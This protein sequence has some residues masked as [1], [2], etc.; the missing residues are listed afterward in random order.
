MMPTLSPNT[1]AI[2]LLTAP[3]I[4]GRGTSSSELLTPGE[5]KRLARHLREI[6]RQPADLVSPEAA[7][8]LRACHPVIDESRLQ[9]LLGRGF[10]LS[11]VIERWQTRALWVVSRADTQ[12]P[13]RLKARLRED[14]PAVIYGCGDMVLLETGGLAVV[15][16]RHVAD[17]LIDYTMAV[18]R[19]AA[20]AGRTLVS[21][22]AKG[23]DQAA[24]RGALEAGG[25]VCG[26]LADSLEKTT[27]N[28]EHRNLLLDG[29]LVLMSPYDPSAGFNVG[30]AMQRNKLIY[31]MADSSLVVGSDL[32]KGGTWAGATEQLDKLKFVPVYVRSTGEPSIGLDALREK[33][34]LPWPNPQDVDALRA[35][36]DTV[37]PASVQPPQSAFALFSTDETTEVPLSMP[38]VAEPPP[39]IETPSES[40]PP[41]A[42]PPGNKALE[43]TPEPAAPADRLFA[44]VR[45]AITSLLKTTMKD[46][47]VAATLD[48][49]SAQAKAWLQRL[50]NEGVIEKQKKP[51]G[52]I[53]KQSRLFE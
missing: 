25:K 9:R 23:I 33:G 16:S 5:Y 46:S 11:Q 8:L 53:V 49:S 6:Q 42:E 31:A 38:W 30:N 7:D 14:A 36:F 18:G 37:T 34:A 29:Q 44:V 17:A 45:E 51:A 28:R 26:V 41:P 12:Y 10:L 4:A 52:Y 2:L 15:G 24:M 13:R 39:A 1:Q 47:E 22:G 35:V 19:L 3:L 50:V 20:R 21:G 32:N 43:P 48:V 27:M 40:A